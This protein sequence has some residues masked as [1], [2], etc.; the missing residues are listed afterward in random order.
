MFLHQGDCTHTI[1]F[2]EMRMAHGGDVQD[3]Q[4]YPLCVLYNRVPRRKCFICN[5]FAATYVWDSLRD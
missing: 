2:T 5:L 4:A 1:V 3:P